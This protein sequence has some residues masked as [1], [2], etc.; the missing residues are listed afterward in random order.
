VS[1]WNFLPP[2]EPKRTPLALP[3]VTRKTLLISKTLGIEGGQLLRPGRL[4]SPEGV[5]LRLRGNPHGRRGHAPRYQALLQAD[6]ELEPSAEAFPGATFS[7]REHRQL[8]CRCLLLLCTARSRQ[9]GRG[10]H[11][12]CR[13][14]PVGTCTTLTAA[15][16]WRTRRDSR[17]LCGPHLRRRGRRCTTNPPT[18]VEIRAKVEKHINEH[19]PEACG[20]ARSVSP[21]LRCWMELNDG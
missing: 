3:C 5:Q 7:G 14:P 1:F 19:L 20:R 8:G 13:V 11:R 16:F 6:P 15:R 12:G 2:D 18:L 4:R 10:V 17:Q 9:G 21:S